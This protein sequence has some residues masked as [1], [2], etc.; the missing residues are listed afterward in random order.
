MKKESASSAIVDVNGRWGT[1]P[2]EP[3]PR[4]EDDTFISECYADNF[5]MVY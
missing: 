1:F 4:A 3:R 2:E 5:L